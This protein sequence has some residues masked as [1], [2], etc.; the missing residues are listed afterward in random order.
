MAVT[1]TATKTLRHSVIKIIG[2]HN[3]YVL[4]LCPCKSN[5]VYAVGKF[6]NVADTF[7]PLVVR[8]SQLRAQLPRVI[9]YCRRFQDCSAIY[10]LFRNLLG[11]FNEPPGAP[12][13]TRFRLVEMFTSVTDSDIKEEIL[14]LFT[15]GSKLRIVVDTI[16]FGMGVDC[17]DVREVIH[18][19]A[20]DDA[21]GYIQETGRAGRDGLPALV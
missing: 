6:N 21:E 9:I 5:L 19:G 1:A 16:A 13:I 15:V 8:L 2:L 12:D 4:A 10:I 18:V 11:S 14:K 20:P 7:G 3:P 17:R